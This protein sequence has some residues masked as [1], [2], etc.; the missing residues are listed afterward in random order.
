MAVNVSVRS[1]DGV[2]LA[3]GPA[4]LLQPQQDVRWTA[5]HLLVSLKNNKTRC[6]DGRCFLL[7]NGSLQLTHAT[8][9]DAGRYRQEVFDPE[10]QRLRQQD[11]LLRVQSERP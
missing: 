11:F 3:S 4:H 6:G 8:A 2:L 5:H 1:G 7:L 10:G 9:A